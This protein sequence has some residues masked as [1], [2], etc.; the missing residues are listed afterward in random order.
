MEEL[1][2]ILEKERQAEAF[3]EEAKEKARL[4]IEKEK[5]KL[6]K[7]LVA[8]QCLNEK[9]KEAFLALEK[10]EAENVARINQ[11]KLAAELDSLNSRA[12]KNFAKAADFVSRFLFAP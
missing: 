6:E 2:K 12:Q 3:V 5:Q 7:E 1:N 10:R 8:A 4:A 9:E 11:K